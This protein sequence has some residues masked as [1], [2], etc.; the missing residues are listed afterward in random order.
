VSDGFGGALVTRIVLQ[1]EGAGEARAAREELAGLVNTQGQLGHVAERSS[2]GVRTLRTGLTALAFQATGTAGPLGKVAEGLV[3]F[4]GGTGVALL[5]AGAIGGVGLAL[6]ALT[7]PTD[8]VVERA[9]KLAGT[10]RV[11]ASAGEQL[12][13]VLQE[14]GKAGTTTTGRVGALLGALP[15]GLGQLELGQDIGKQFIARQSERAAAAGEAAALARRG[16]LSAEA[17]KAIQQA[18]REN[19]LLGKSAETVARLTA[20]WRGYS[21]DQTKRFVD[22]SRAHEERL[23]EIA[24]REAINELLLEGER[25]QGGINLGQIGLDVAGIGKLPLLTKDFPLGKLSEITGAKVPFLDK[26]VKG[27]EEIIGRKLGGG[28]S[29]QLIGALFGLAG[30]AQGGAGGVLAGAGGLLSEL[31][32]TSPLG[33]LVSGLGGLVGLFGG[34][35]RNVTIDGYTQRALDQQR[36]QEENKRNVVIL[37]VVDAQGRVRDQIYDITRYQNR[38]GT[39]GGITSRSDGSAV[40]TRSG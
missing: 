31:M 20:Q 38:G 16:A 29:T 33:A 3:V 2:H 4:G 23:Q 13:D 27:T 24:D 21:A 5:A 6:K 40:T 8:A 11:A 7:G 19:Q 39:A 12:R 1:R 28:D 14:I 9:A 10:F 25:I 35:G 32:K 17:D 34:G 30:S 26:D 22:A 15:F 37:Q 18:E 36:R